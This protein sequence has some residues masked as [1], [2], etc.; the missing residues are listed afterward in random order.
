VNASIG[1]TFQSGGKVISLAGS[2]AQLLNQLRGVL[3]TAALAVCATFVILKV[4]DAFVG[5][6]VTVE[7]EDSGLDLTQDR[8]S[9]YND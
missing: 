1:N 5:L 9:A 4:V 7:E 8:E 6:R 2:G 3:F